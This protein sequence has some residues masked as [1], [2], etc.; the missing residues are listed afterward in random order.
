MRRCHKGRDAHWTIKFT[1]AKPHE[2]GTVASANLGN[3]TFG[4]KSH[5]L[6]DKRFRLV[7]DCNA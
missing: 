6:I 7:R 1:R 3:P 4:Y 2:D 5:I